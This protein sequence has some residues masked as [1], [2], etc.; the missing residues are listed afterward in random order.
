MTC[1]WIENPWVMALSSDLYIL[2]SDSDVETS[3]L[4]KPLW[5]ITGICSHAYSLTVGNHAFLS[6]VLTLISLSLDTP[7][8]SSGLKSLSVCQ[9]FPGGPVGRTP[10][11]HCPQPEFNPWSSWKPSSVDWDPERRAPGFLIYP[12]FLFL[13][14]SSLPQPDGPAGF[15]KALRW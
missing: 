2:L 3:H 12:L 14:P 8:R 6:G 9:E 13:I 7:G 15:L 4:E 1:W 5:S 10:C 11:F